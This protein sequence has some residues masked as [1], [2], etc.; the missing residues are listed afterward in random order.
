M[1]IASRGYAGDVDTI[2]WAHLQRV[3]GARY[4]CSSV[5]EARVLPHN[6]GT[7][8]IVV[9][10]GYLGG[11]GILDQITE[12]E[13]YTLP[14]VTAGRRF[15]L[16]IA[17]REWRNVF[18]TRIAHIDAGTSLPMT[19]PARTTK[20]GIEDDQPLALASLAANDTI[21]SIVYDLR[22]L[23]NRDNFNLDPQL[24]GHPGWFNFLAAEG[25][26]I[27]TGDESYYRRLGAWIPST[28]THVSANGDTVA[29][30][31]RGGVTQGA[32]TDPDG[33][34]SLYV[35]LRQTSATPIAFDSH[36]HVGD[37]LIHR[38]PAALRPWADQTGIGIDFRAAAGGAFTCWGRITTTG[39]VTVQSGPP[40]ISVR[41]STAQTTDEWDLRFA[42]HYRR[43]S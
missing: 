42:T 29:G 19:M 34:V 39:N 25:V 4:W 14:A 16:I 21:P 2:D 17:K 3:A 24:A 22:A 1:T 5:N 12:P 35:E 27:H 30:F 36:G 8:Q 38:L 32:I 26:T 10:S 33:W 43:R 40:G 31:S 18:K 7:R 41:R 28:G 37:R 13:L 11:W 15:F 9:T 6:Y 23:G 20:P